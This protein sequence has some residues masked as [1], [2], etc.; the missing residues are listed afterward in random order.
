M[1]IQ[2]AVTFINKNDDLENSFKYKKSGPKGRF[3]YNAVLSK[4]L[5]NAFLQHLQVQEYLRQITILLQV[6]VPGLHKRI[7]VITL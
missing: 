1:P 2:L 5:M 7:N 6:L 4:V 3:F